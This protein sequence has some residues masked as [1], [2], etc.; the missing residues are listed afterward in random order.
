MKPG[1]RYVQ[2]GNYEHMWAL[3]YLAVRELNREEDERAAMERRKAFEGAK[4]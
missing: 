4:V 3:T 2:D 1:T